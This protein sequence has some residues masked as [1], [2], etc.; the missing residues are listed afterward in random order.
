[1]DVA[2]TTNS[3]IVDV[4]VESRAI[5]EAPDGEDGDDWAGANAH[6]TDEATEPVLDEAGHMELPPFDHDRKHWAVGAR[7]CFPDCYVTETLSGGK[8]RECRVAYGGSSQ[9][10]S[11]KD[12]EQLN[13]FTSASE[14]GYQLQVCPHIGME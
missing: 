5:V 6:R 12:K 3:A 13:V 10:S 2:G 1:M 7:S 14:N 11:Q 4:E 9:K 8:L